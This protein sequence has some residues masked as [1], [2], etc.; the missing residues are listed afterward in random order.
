MNKL[1]KA[2]KYKNG[3]KIKEWTDFFSFKSENNLNDLR[4]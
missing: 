3:K 2:S 1:V 4:K